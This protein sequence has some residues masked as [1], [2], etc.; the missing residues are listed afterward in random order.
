MVGIDGPDG[1]RRSDGRAGHL[2]FGPHLTLQPGKYVAGMRLCKLPGS[3]GGPIDMDAYSTQLGILAHNRIAAQ[4]LFEQTVSLVPLEFSIEALTSA[5]EV[6]L[7]VDRDVL[8]ELHEL[9]VFS[10]VASNRGGQ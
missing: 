8:I 3:A 4:N 9:V 10:R 1:T 2:S 5:I 7:H 6:R